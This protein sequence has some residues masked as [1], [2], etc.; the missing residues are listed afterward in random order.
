[1]EGMTEQEA[2][3]IAE[4]TLDE[5]VRPSIDVEIVVA[6]MEEFHTCWVAGYNSREYIEHD[7]LSAALL[8]NGPVII[9]KAT[10][11]ARLGGTAQ[12]VEEQ[13]DPS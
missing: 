3:D 1:V 6:S 10:G 12:P 4:R 2:R 8:G 13:L 7:R 11:T 5:L 9:N